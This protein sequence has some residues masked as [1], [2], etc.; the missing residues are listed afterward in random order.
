MVSLPQLCVERYGQADYGT[1]STH[2]KR[3]ILGPDRRSLDPAEIQ[4]IIKGLP[5]NL[6]YNALASGPTSYDNIR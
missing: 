3:P 5:T 2:G 6:L 1:K 4:P